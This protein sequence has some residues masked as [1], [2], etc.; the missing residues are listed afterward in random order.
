MK[1]K[2]HNLTKKIL[3]FVLIGIIASSVTMLSY[4]EAKEVKAVVV[5]DDIAVASTVALILL[6]YGYLS[7]NCFNDTDGTSALA[8][9]WEDA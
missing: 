6:A 5:V 3:P 1:K 9:A 2:I 4:N 7:I 8:E